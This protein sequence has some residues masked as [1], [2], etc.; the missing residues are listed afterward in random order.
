MGDKSTLTE[1]EV[2]ESE[3]WAFVH[4]GLDS[5][6]KL[7]TP[8]ESVYNGSTKLLA[9]APIG[10]VFVSAG[11]EG[12]VAGRLSALRQ[13]VAAHSK[14]FTETV[15]FPYSTTVRHLAFSSDE[16]HLAVC[17]VDGT[18]AVFD[19]AKAMADNAL[20]SPVFEVKTPSG[21]VQDIQSRP[22]YG[23][24]FAVLEEDGSLRVLNVQ[25]RSFLSLASDVTAITWTKKGKKILASSKINN[26]IIFYTLNGAPALEWPVPGQPEG[27]QIV[28]LLW[29]K[30]IQFVAVVKQ[31]PEEED[32]E[33]PV[34]AV[35]MVT[36]DASKRDEAV[37]AVMEDVCLPF[38][39]LSRYGWW[40]GEA[41]SGWHKDIESLVILSSA[42][43][44]DIAFATDKHVIAPLEDS[45]RAALPY[46][47]DDTS[48]VGVALDI[49]SAV[50]LKQPF[51]GCDECDPLPLFWVV[52]NEGHLM[53]WS[54]VEK[55]L[56]K[57]GE[58]GLE[59]LKAKYKE[60]VEI[61]AKNEGGFLSSNTSPAKSVPPK[62]PAASSLL[63]KEE[64]T[65]S[66]FGS[67]KE[68]SNPFAEKAPDSPGESKKL[69]T[70]GFTA[71]GTAFGQ[72]SFGSGPSAFGKPEESS[73][74]KPVEPSFAKPAE[75]AFGKQAESSLGSGSAFGQSPGFG[76]KPTFGSSGS[77]FGAPA[78]SAF[79]TS[80][81][82]FGSPAQSTFG[83]SGAGFGLPA[84]SSFG[85]SGTTTPSVSQ[86]GFGAFASQGTGFI[87]AANQSSASGASQNNGFGQNQTSG[88]G[89][90][91]STNSGFGALGDKA[92]ETNWNDETVPSAK[93]AEE[94]LF[95]KPLSTQIRGGDRTPALDKDS[96]DEGD[97]GIASSGEE[98][99]SDLA[100]PGNAANQST[101]DLDLGRLSTATPTAKPFSFA[102]MQSSTTSPFGQ[103]SSYSN[104]FAKSDSIFASGKASTPPGAAIGQTKGS[105]FGGFQSPSG[106]FSQSD[107]GGLFGTFPTDEKK[108]A[109]DET[110]VKK[111]ELDKPSTVALPESDK[112]ESPVAVKS[113]PEEERTFIKTEPIEDAP[114]PPTPTEEERKA[115][116]PVHIPGVTTPK[117]QPEEDK[118]EQSPLSKDDSLI[119]AEGDSEGSGELVHALSSEEFV[120]VSGKTSE[121]ESF[122]DVDKAHRAGMSESSEGEVSEEESES[123]EEDES[124]VESEE[125]EELEEPDLE[126]HE[127]KPMIMDIPL[128]EVLSEPEDLEFE[129]EL[130]DLLDITEA[131]TPFEVLENATSEA[132][133]MYLE[134]IC[135]FKALNHN[136]KSIQRYTRWHK[137]SDDLNYDMG[138]VTQV[139]I[140]RLSQ[141]STVSYLADTLLKDVVQ[142]KNLSEADEPK[143]KDLHKMLSSAS[144]QLSRIQD[145]IRYK[146]GEV[147]ERALRLR[148]LPVQAVELQ[149]KL[150]LNSAKLEKDLGHIEAENNVLKSQLSRY[151]SSQGPS[152]QGIRDSIRRISDLALSKYEKVLALGQALKP[153]PVYRSSTP[154]RRG[155]HSATGTPVK[156][157]AN[158]SSMRSPNISHVVRERALD[159]VEFLAKRTGSK[160]K[161][162][163][164]DLLRDRTANDVLTSPS[165]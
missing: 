121:D 98:D 85:S 5:G 33:D 104:P 151:G 129:P 163:V 4:L 77:G 72:S 12:I 113:E 34:F 161:T 21:K 41:L 122:S 138:D 43:S 136:L 32:S 69:P 45:D 24:D 116:R 155:Y 38:G 103:T 61:A 81:S 9:I 37:W 102:S 126:G 143:I 83:T 53:G 47:E 51:M 115:F 133:Y 107:K 27:S 22:Q 96:D 148:G 95:S 89:A 142:A 1:L 31:P 55:K 145:L 18:I 29:V 105:L 73:L 159:E 84:Q 99:E 101:V 82:G 10:D 68:I 154:Q 139:D 59:K 165:L 67:T 120:E 124:E 25:D 125:E 160:F 16:S 110:E 146:N 71:P 46:T 109:K 118:D 150:R 17:G 108:A 152:I 93:P 158:A 54:I 42:P 49:F 156:D 149:R 79:G 28:Y 131:E 86:S 30:S 164:G 144:L 134:T 19:A 48:P 35:Y 88:F 52:N 94:S 50:Q 57:A 15:V 92:G 40:Y 147:S 75:S 8:Y 153:E 87:Q 2:I 11:K 58:L 74:G 130:S 111:E 162:D 44:S 62:E 70:A 76:A 26:S 3:D 135:Q 56:A 60:S 64:P 114:L 66:P 23:Q 128:E 141:A 157:V 39:D 137:D 140:W 123:E 13:A 63:K 119:K 127:V 91:A 7:L 132:D 106:T 36:V 80:S 20:G 14:E 65:A 78:Q 117:Q 97:N 6:I 100:T 112:E 90:F